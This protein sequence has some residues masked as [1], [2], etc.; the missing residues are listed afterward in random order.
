M[1]VFSGSRQVV[2][3][4]YEAEVSQR[5]LEASLS[6]D[7]KSALEC[8]AD[9]FVDVNFVGA[10]CLKTRKAEVVLRE[11]SPSEVRVEYE[12]FKTDVT[13]LFLAVHVGNVA[14]VKKLLVMQQKISFF[15]SFIALIG[16]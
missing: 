13:A 7:L 5:L 4:D 14:L 15:L 16:L 6:G 8:I 2:P 3:V 10:V 9:P 11:E 12:E 1:T